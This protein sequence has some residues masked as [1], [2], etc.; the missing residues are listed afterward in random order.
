MAQSFVLAAAKIIRFRE[1]HNPPFIAKL[2]RPEKKTEYRTFAGAIN[3]EQFANSPDLKTELTNAIIG[4]L[5]A[6]SAMSSQALAS[7]AVRDGLRDV[8]L[9]YAGLYEALRH[10]AQ[11]R[12]LAG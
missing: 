11:V 12:D 3:K 9:N 1:T 4:A 7:E 5:D 10:R 6:H 8:L 2:Y